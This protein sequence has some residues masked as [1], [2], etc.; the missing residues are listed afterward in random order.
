MLT[1]LQCIVG[2]VDWKVYYDLIQET[3]SLNSFA[4][5]I[6]IM[7][8][9]FAVLN[10][11]TSVFMDKALNMTKPDIDSLM[12][13]RHRHDIADAKG[14]LQICREFLP[15]ENNGRITAVDFLR[16]MAEQRFR[17]YCEVRNIEIRDAETFFTMLSSATHTKQV[18]LST[19][20]AG[21]M[22]LKGVASSIDLQAL[23]FKIK[24]I[25]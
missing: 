12:L 13:E 23:S 7:F 19:F 14:L 24:L 2:G 22:R 16:F 25:H 4:F 6:Y 1:L 3:G 17:D 5:L 15:Q 20:V 21:V 8:F 11:V 10:I 18:E 9:T